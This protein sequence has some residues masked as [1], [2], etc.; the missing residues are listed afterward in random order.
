MG[1]FE[2]KLKDYWELQKS[3][4][5]NIQF[6]TFRTKISLNEKIK[7]LTTAGFIEWILRVCLI[8]GMFTY[9]SKRIDI[10]QEDEYKNWSKFKELLSQ[11]Q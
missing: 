5:N 11:M 8:I 10:K 7:G 3:D 1:W 2:G 4:I 6:G 9:D